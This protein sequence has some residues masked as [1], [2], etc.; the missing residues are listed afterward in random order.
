M[1]DKIT[2]DDKV[3]LTTSALPR[4]N[5]CTDADLNEIKQ[6][7]NANADELDENTTN[8]NTILQQ[9][10]NLNNKLNGTVLFQNSNGV[11]SGSIS[12]NDSIANYTRLV[13][14][15]NDGQW[16]GEQLTDGMTTARLQMNDQG[17]SN[18]MIRIARLNVVDNTTLEFYSN[19][20]AYYDGSSWNRSG[21]I[22][23]LGKIIGYKY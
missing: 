20:N 19:N 4:A 14:Y 18:T 12:L 7:V 21:S 1:A 3:S 6:V 8:I 13:F 9:I 17:A 10:T 23:I 5:K 16:L 15:S 11:S 22:V 2:F